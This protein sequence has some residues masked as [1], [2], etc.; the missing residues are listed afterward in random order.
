MASDSKTRSELPIYFYSHFILILP[1]SQGKSNTGKNFYK[2]KILIYAAQDGRTMN[3]A[4]ERLIRFISTDGLVL[5]GE[6]ILPNAD[7]DLG[8]TTAD[9]R[10]RAKVVGGNDIYDTTGATKVTEEVVTVEKLLG[11]LESGDV[12]ILRCVGLNYKAHSSW[13]ICPPVPQPPNC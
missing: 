10:L 4:W 2:R 8:T 7:F 5:W 6:P 3:V 9:T 11:P 1:V 12:P 13:L